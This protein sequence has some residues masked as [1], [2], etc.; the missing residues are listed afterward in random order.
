[1][2]RNLAL[3][4]DYVTSTG[5]PEPYLKRI[6][7]AGFT[8]ILWGH[9]W[10]DDFIYSD[11]EIRQ[12][13]QWCKKYGLKTL[14]IHASDG[15]EKN[16]ISQK[17]YER[18]AGAEL[19]KNRI[20]MAA[21]LSCKVIIM[22]LQYEP[23]NKIENKL[24]WKTVHKTFDELRPFAK[25]HKV[26]IALEIISSHKVDCDE[27]KKIFSEY[28]SDFLGFCYDSGH[29]NLGV[30]NQLLELFKHRLIAVH[31]NDNDGHTS[32]HKNLFSGTV[33][34]NKIAKLIS[35]SSYVDCMGLEITTNQQGIKE[36]T[37]FLKEAH[38]LGIKF[39]QM[40]E[41]ERKQI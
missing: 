23:E 6:S 12:I 28:D 27:I 21:Q 32:Q 16:W 40:V 15:K 24:Y 29:G 10:N 13:A 14:N 34:W 8:H 2:K 18:R 20:Y 19:V 35:Q 37:K 17:E 4:T 41:A 3:A 38:R 25:K 1:M 26:K 39:S 22:H 11:S 36:E 30:G 9:H 7:D 31:L 33:D 5:S